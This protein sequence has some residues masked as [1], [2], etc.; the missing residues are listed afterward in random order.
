M[1]I[2]KTIQDIK[3]NK[4]FT[5][6]KDSALSSF[7]DQKEIKEAREGEIIY[8]TGDQSNAIY[9][10]IKGDIRV[11]FSANNYVSNRIFNDFFG[12]KEL[13]DE[14]RRISSAVAFS[15]L[16]Y[17]R[18][19]KAV[20]K[21]I[22]AKNPVISSNLKKYGELKLPDVN[23]DLERK[24]DIVDRKK[25]I[26]FRAFSSAGNSLKDEE[27][28]EITSPAVVTQQIIPDLGSL[29]DVLPEEEIITPKKDQKNGPKQLQVELLDD[30]SGFK[31]WQFEESNSPTNTN[32]AE[33]IKKSKKSEE[34][35]VDASTEKSKLT[36]P[37]ES[38][39]N[40]EVVRRIFAGIDR[41]YSSISI[42]ELVINAKRA[43]KDLINAEGVDV[44]L[45]DEKLSSIQ[46][47]ITEAD[48]VKQEQY[49]LSEGLTGSCALQKKIL[50]FERPTEDSRFSAKIDQPG[51]ARLKRIV[52]FPVVSDN[53]ETIAVIQFARENRKFT[54]D[55]ISNLAIMSKQIETAIERTKLLEVLIKEEKQNSGDRLRELITNEI[56]VPLT[57]INNYTEILSEKN[58]PSEAD[59]IIRMLQKQAHSVEDISEALFISL[60]G[61]LHLSGSNIHF[62]ELIDD[63]L[64]LLSEYCEA[65]DVKLFKKIGESALVNIDRG[66]FY[67]AVFQLI[68]ASCDDCRKGGKIYFGTEFKEGSIT[69]SIQNEGK[70]ALAEPLGDIQEYFYSKKT[71]TDDEMKLLLAKKLIHLHSGQINL[72]SIKGNGST[73]RITLPV[74]Q[75]ENK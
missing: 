21:N 57:I 55:D 44:V 35:V 38:G 3:N 7:F 1:P 6:I 5:G 12:E 22:V 52:Y 49:P 4:L 45:I 29:E 65:R 69:I 9:L 64:E 15:K 67:T 33:P 54:E 14:T 8:K 16:V 58:L 27:P 62:N 36:L 31:N 2:Y 46:R 68:K 61:E 71:F 50:N 24:F 10:I 17:Y 42:S 41:I 28:V 23:V 19:D 43:V 18:L 48:K 37:V 59:D 56:K 74:I 20:F 25:P 75:V 34:A 72:E 32:A 30:P 13:I 40:R 11:K 73:F 70:G 26:S 63:I 51:S 66:K 53:G 60:I 47:I 39:I